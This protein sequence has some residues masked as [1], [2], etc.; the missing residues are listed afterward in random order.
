MLCGGVSRVVVGLHGSLVSRAATRLLV[1]RR[2]PE[3]SQHDIQTSQL[4]PPPTPSLLNLFGAV[5]FIFS[6]I[7]IL[8]RELLVPDSLRAQ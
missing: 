1:T 7:T 5:L 2:V 3:T 8:I 6:N 4:Y